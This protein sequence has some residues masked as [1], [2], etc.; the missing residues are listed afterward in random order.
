MIHRDH[1][2]KFEFA[3]ATD[4]TDLIVLNVKSKSWSFYHKFELFSDFFSKKSSLYRFSI[5]LSW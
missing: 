2:I 3:N 1:N 4:R 5:K